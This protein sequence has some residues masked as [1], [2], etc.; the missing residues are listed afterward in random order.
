MGTDLN[1]P[2]YSLDD[3]FFKKMAER[4]FDYAMVDELLKLATMEGILPA[5]LSG[6]GGAAAGSLPISIPTMGALRAPGIDARMLLAQLISNIL[7]G[8]LEKFLTGRE[9]DP[10]GFLARHPIIDILLRGGSAGRSQAIRDALQRSGAVP[11]SGEAQPMNVERLK[12]ILRTALPSK[13]AR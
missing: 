13:T 8:P 1:D 2:R 4:V 11:I 6:A 12:E 10:S 3:V 7:G 9:L 5:I